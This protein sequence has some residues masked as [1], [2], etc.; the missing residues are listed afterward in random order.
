[1]KNPTH[2]VDNA[3]FLAA[4]KTHRANRQRA[5]ETNTEAPLVPEFIGECF[6]K[7]ATHLS[8]KPNFMSYTFREDMIS[9]GVENCLVYVDN[10]DPDK[11]SN[12]FG[13][14]T[15]VIYYAFVR[16]IQKEKRH[17]Y[18]RFKLIEQ[19]V[20]NGGAQTNVEGATVPHVDSGML[21]FDNVQDFI[22]RY[23]S[24]TASRRERRRQSKAKQS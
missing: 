9:D 16:R 22:T 5:L 8:Y 11:S 18:I 2:Y 21:K 23:D 14:F 15:Q 4:L 1:M 6:L 3:A 10:F 12:P 13:Y 17:T 20:I 19:S 7:I 24:Y